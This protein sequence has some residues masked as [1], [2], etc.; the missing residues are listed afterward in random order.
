VAWFSVSGMSVGGCV[1]PEHPVS[2]AVDAIGSAL[3][4]TADVP[5]WSLSDDEVETL[6]LEAHRLEGRLHDVTLR[7]V[8]EADRRRASDRAAAAS[9]SAWL[10]SHLQM[11]PGDARRRVTLSTALA[12]RL[13]ATRRALADGT[14]SREH[15][16]VVMKVMDSL[17]TSLG[18]E[19]RADAERQ[20][21]DWCRQF[22]PHDVARLG[23]KLSE[24]IDP[25][26][27]EEREAKLLEKQERD[28]A[29]QRHLVFGPDG[30][31]RHFLRGQF[32]SESAATIAAALDPLAQ[33][34]PS[35]AEGPDTRTPGQRYADAFVE[36][37]RRQLVSGDLPSRG[38]EK[39][40]VVITMDLDKLRRSVGSGLLDNGDRLSVAAV[41]RLA[42]DAQIIPA[43]LDGDGRPLDLGR[44]SRTFTAAQ[45]RALSLRDGLGCAFP[46]CDRPV[47]WCDGHHIRHWVDGGAT[48]LSNGVLLCCHHHTV[49]HQG[50]WAVRMAVDGRPE[51]LPPRWI[52]RER[53]PRRNI[54]HRVE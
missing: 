12:E 28:A 4:G 9:T 33:P 2:G 50:D 7:L 51:F 34:R 1:K 11:A 22:N 38:G 19:L 54:L 45:R 6:L 24:I 40:Q 25:D 44:S 29:R 31:G 15:A 13:E 20:L 14:I 42:C 8:A 30:F 5:M 18:S 43:L 47:A 26:T 21:I 27:A 41:R 52:D 53:K 39:P 10:R 48:D 36:L 16:L 37:R 49:I 32:D 35:T 17:S 23:C 3:D 46:D